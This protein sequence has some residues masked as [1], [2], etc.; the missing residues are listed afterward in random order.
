[1][2]TNGG[3]YSPAPRPP[4]PQPGRGGA[5]ASQTLD[6]GLRLLEAIADAP[7]PVT[8]AEAAASVGLHRSVAYRLLRTLEDHRLV[9]RQAGDVFTIGYGVV[10]LSRRAASDL[11]TAATVELQALAEEVDLAAF[12][13]VRDGDDAVTTVVAEPSTPGTWF[14]HRVGSHHPV[15]LGAPG[16]AMAS[17]A[18]ARPGDRAA[19]RHARSHGWTVSVGEVFEGVTAVAAPIPGH[20]VPAAVAVTFVGDLEPAQLG[21]QVAA[22]ATRIAHRLA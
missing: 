15:A 14:T 7:H 9:Q 3:T 19:V 6:R 21:P 4:T 13:M 2:P 11:A 8:I 1:M 10:T 5:P 16:A 17:L 22:A 12:I 20:R 18:P